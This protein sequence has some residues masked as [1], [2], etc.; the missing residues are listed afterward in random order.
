MTSYLFA[1]LLFLGLALGAMANIMLHNVTGGPWFQAVRAPLLAG[2]RLVPLAAL[3][4]IPV[5]AGMRA[6]YPWAGSGGNWWLSPAFFVARSIV[7]LLAWSALALLVRRNAGKGLSALGLIVYTFT[8]SLAAVDWIG[9]LVPQ[10]Y[11]TAFGLVVGVG[12][13]LGAMALAVAFAGLSGRAREGAEAGQTF[14]DLGNLLLMYVL[15]WA[16]LA[17][18]EFLIIWVGNLPREISWYVPRLQTGWF[19]LGVLLVVVHFFAPL[20]ILLFRAAKR[21]PLLLGSLAA[22]LLAAHVADVYWLVAPSVRP[23]AFS[24]AWTDVLCF[25]IAALLWAFAWRPR[26]GDL[27][28]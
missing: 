22:V 11:S 20:A 25:V 24:I 13:M 10:W 3:L 27:H 14:I 19:G 2:A 1:W 12:Q 7:Y 18:S 4:G 8:V 15:L 21:S 26:M 16:Y 28:G 6:I 9:S 17:Y 5:L 23:Q